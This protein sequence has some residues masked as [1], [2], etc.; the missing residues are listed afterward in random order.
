ME[1]G[2]ILIRPR[3]HTHVLECRIKPTARLPNTAHTHHTR[4][5]AEGMWAQSQGGNGG[6]GGKKPTFKVLKIRVSNRAN[7]SENTSATT[8]SRSPPISRLS[9]KALH[10]H[11]AVI[12]ERGHKGVRVS[13]PL[14]DAC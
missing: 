7:S 2:F 13:S 10:T 14:Q 6:R 12:T 8:M 1:D 5:P 3:S 9:V 11:T 4:A